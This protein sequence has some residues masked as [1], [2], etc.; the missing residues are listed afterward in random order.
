M[1]EKK[2]VWAMCQH[3]LESFKQQDTKRVLVDNGVPHYIIVHKDYV[4]LYTDD[5]SKVKT[6][7]DF[8]S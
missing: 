4:D 3:S 7:K 1:T 8:K 6:F 5:P 2:Q